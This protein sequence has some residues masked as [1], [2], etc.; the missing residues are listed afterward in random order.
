MTANLDPKQTAP[1]PEGRFKHLRG[2]SEVL[3]LAL[4]IESIFRTTILP[5]SSGLAT[6]RLSYLS[7][8]WCS[9]F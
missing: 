7:C 1:S 9:R 3:Q 6:W 4:N 5:P 8:D 2:F